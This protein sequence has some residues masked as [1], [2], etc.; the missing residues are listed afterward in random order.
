MVKFLQLKMTGLNQTV[1]KEPSSSDIQG[2][3]ESLLD[4]TVKSSFLTMPSNSLQQLSKGQ[5]NPSMGQTPAV[6]YDSGFPH[7]LV[8]Y[9]SGFN[10]PL[11][12][13]AFGILLVLQ[14]W[15]LFRRQLLGRERDNS[16]LLL[17]QGEQAQNSENLSNFYRASRG[18]K[19]Q[20][21]SQPN[22]LFLKM[23]WSCQNLLPKRITTLQ[24]P[25]RHKGG[26]LSQALG[27]LLHREAPQP[28]GSH[29]C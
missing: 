19:Y 10:L 2:I 13:T 3:D 17:Y 9:V 1:L 4:F 14:T 29:A 22:P 26:T 25:E 8:S 6:E 11:T 7:Q 21:R 27:L 16:H 24:Q 12:T 5:A 18:G 15:P 20:E 28:Q 23:Q